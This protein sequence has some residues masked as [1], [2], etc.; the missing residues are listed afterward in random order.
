MYILVIYLAL[1]LDLLCVFPTCTR[2]LHFGPLLRVDFHSYE[3]PDIIIVFLMLSDVAFYFI[4][5]RYCLSICL[6]WLL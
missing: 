4:F 5:H 1:G 6:Y 2:I 3:I